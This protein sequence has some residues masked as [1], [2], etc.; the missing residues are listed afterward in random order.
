VSVDASWS[1]GQQAPLSS[2]AAPN[3][4][5]LR[6]NSIATSPGF[7]SNFTQ[8]PRWLRFVRAAADSQ[9]S[10]VVTTRTN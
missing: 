1:D 10:V 6:Y 9:G 4:N 2:G 5:W 3:A 7:M 8:G